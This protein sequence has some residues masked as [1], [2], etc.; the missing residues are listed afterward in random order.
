M[1]NYHDYS[2]LEV[3]DPDDIGVGTG[4]TEG[5][6]R[7][8]VSLTGTKINTHLLTEVYWVSL[9]PEC[10]KELYELLTIVSHIWDE[11]PSESKS[12]VNSDALQERKQ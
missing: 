3:A 2:R 4:D 11:K 12:L 10:A 6:P 9:T 1:A 7:I 5:G 8:C